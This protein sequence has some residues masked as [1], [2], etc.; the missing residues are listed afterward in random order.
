MTTKTILGVKGWDLSEY[1]I[2][3]NAILGIRDSGK[4]YTATE[5]AE[6]LFDAGI[7]FIALDPIGVWHSLRV[8]GKGRGYPVVVAGGRHGDLPL[9]VKNAGSI[10]RAAMEARVSLVIDLFSTE[11]SKADWRRIVRETVEILLHENVD[12]GLRH[13]FIEEAAEFVPQ[14]PR[15]GLVFDAVERLV[16]MGGNSKLGCTLINQRSADLNKSVLELCANVFVHRQKGKNTLLDLKKWFT[17]LDLTDAE[18][19]RIADSL[20]NMKSGECWALINDL[21]KPVFLKIPAKN[22]QHPDRRAVVVKGGEARKP[23]PADAFVAQMTAKLADKDKPPAKAVANPAV[24]APGRQNPSKTDEKAQA[25]AIA[26]A[27]QEGAD[28]I[29]AGIPAL[30][31]GQ[32]AVSFQMGVDWARGVAILAAKGIPNAD[33]IPARRPIAALAAAMKGTA[34][35][36]KASAP[37]SASGS[38]KPAAQPKRIASSADGIPAP[39]RKVLASIGFWSSV[40]TDQP[41]RSQVAGVAGYSPSSGG[42]NNLL[43]QMNTAGLITLPKPGHVALADG[44]PFDPLTTEEAKEKVLSVLKAPQRKLVQAML[45]HTSL[46]RDELGAATDYSPSSGGFNNL[47]GSLC[48]LTVFEKPSPGSVSLS[49]WAREVLET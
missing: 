17:L 37:P 35:A 19:K 10:V 4:T 8:P 9:T 39:Q 16:R 12:H 2:S 6:E 41:S 48:S 29:R 26:A 22:S 30:L 43:G 25:A 28:S 36:P 38:P 42:F 33:L 46:T 44:A 21:P 49:A 18:E 13:I 5:A 3:A 7:P 40:G 31:D 32:H 27:R 34:P 1:A 47:I 24:S 15:D 11:M 14:K 20:P 23:V 45:G